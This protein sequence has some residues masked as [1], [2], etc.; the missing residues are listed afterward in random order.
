MLSYEQILD[1]SRN[2]KRARRKREEL[3]M[4]LRHQKRLRF[5][6]VVAQEESS[7]ETEP[8]R[9]FLDMASG[10][11]P[12]YKF[13]KWKRLLR[14]P[15]QSVSVTSSAFSKLSRIFEGRNP[16]YDY[17]F[18]NNELKDDWE[19][20]RGSVLG[21]PNIWRNKAWEYF[22]TEPNSVLVVD[23]P[24]NGRADMSDRYIQPYFYFVKVENIVDFDTKE[25]GDFNWFIYKDEDNALI[26]VID[27]TSYR[28][29]RYNVENAPLSLVRT[30]SGMDMVNIGD[31]VS[32]SEHGLGYCPCKWFA[33]EPIDLNHRDVKLSPITKVLGDL[34][35]YL[36]FST[37][38]R[39]LDTYAEFP[40][41]SGYAEECGFETTLLLHEDGED[42][43]VHCKCHKGFL[44][45]D[46]EQTIMEN[47][48]PLACPVCSRKQDTFGPGTFVKVP[49]PNGDDIP[50]MRNP[51][52]MLSVDRDALD[53]TKDEQERLSSEIITRC[54]G[55]DGNAV[56]TFSISDKQVDANFESQSTI[57]LGVK[58]VFEELQKF[59]DDTCCRLRYGVG[60][61][62]CDIDYGTEFYML[63]TK[64]LR[65][66]YKD[67][68]QGGATESDLSALRKQ[69][70]QTEYRNDQL[71]QQRMLILQ[72]VEPL[73]GVTSEV[74]V[75]LL[76]KGLV[77]ESDVKVKINFDSLIRR[78]EREN[79][80]ILEYGVP[81]MDY[82]TKI[83]TIQK[84]LKDYVKGIGTY[85]R[86]TSVA[87]E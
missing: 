3:A 26:Y 15:L 81:E 34:D 29:Y 58:K 2:G 71:Q 55:I 48:H 61:E 43:D 30:E 31:L 21:E 23:M 76:D 65:T 56:N 14:L 68:K 80:T 78:F 84:I 77:E 69:I 35:W 40:I 53:Y 22:K 20:Y 64:E 46:D 38:K 86:P 37:S 12:A 6:S 79:G 82:Q 62:S 9:D 1:N 42:K 75:N 24:Q 87:S 16:V 63:N 19:W 5:H 44:K 50:D 7:V 4:M 36:F 33:K 60:Y 47:G 67:A 25:N 52:Q 45:D 13:D 41:Y 18:S 59:A 51:I 39:Y 73:N 8:L 11:I 70:V 57:L 66:I 32:E 10:Q 49:V 27:D 17:Q 54:I 83:S 72:D 85:T 28:V 74:A